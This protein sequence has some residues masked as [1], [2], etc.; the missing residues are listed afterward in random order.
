M[1]DVHFESSPLLSSG[2]LNHA[3]V[4]SIGMLYVTVFGQHISTSR[5]HYN[6]LKKD[7]I[8]CATS[9]YWSARNG[10]TSASPSGVW[11]CSLGTCEIVA[12]AYSIALDAWRLNY[13]FGPR[14]KVEIGFTLPEL[15]AISNHG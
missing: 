7:F 8:G 2:S 13:L 1:K 11:D 10:N 6:L 12:P 14:G 5:R 15:Q 9:R 3:H 4:L